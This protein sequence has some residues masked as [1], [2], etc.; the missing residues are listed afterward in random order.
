MTL[1]QPD[2]F[3]RRGG[4]DAMNS[5][6]QQYVTD[7][8]DSMAA[9]PTD[10]AGS[11]DLLRAAARRA[12][13]QTRK[14]LVSRQDADGSWCAELEGDTILES[15]TILLLAFLGREDDGLARRLAAYLLEKQLPEGGWALYP[16]GPPEISGSVKAYFALK[17]TGHDPGAE[18][19][20]RARDA[21]LARGGADAVN[22]HT[23]FYLGPA[24]PDLLRTMS[25]RAAGVRAAAQMVARQPAGRQRLV[26]D[27]H[28]AAVDH[29]GVSPCPPHRAAAGHPRAVPAASRQTG[30]RC[31]V[32]GCPAATGLLSWDRF[33]RTVDRLLKWCQRRRCA[34]AAAQGP[35]GRRTLDARP[36]RPQRRAGRDLSA[37]WSGASIA[38]K[39]LGYADDSPEVEYC[40]RSCDDLVID[41]PQPATARAAALQVAGLGHGHRGPGA[42]GRRRRGRRSGAPRGGRVAAASKQIRAARRLGRDGRCRAGR[43][44]LRVRQRF[45][46]R[47]RRHGDGADGAGSTQFRRRTGGPAAELAAPERHGLPRQRRQPD[48]PA[49][50][51]RACD[52]GRHGGGDRTRP[53]LAA[54]HAER[55]RRLGR[56]RSQQQPRVP[57]LRPL[58]RSQRDDR[59]QHARPDGPRAGSAGPSGPAPGRSGRR[60]G[61]GLRPRRART[62]TEAGSA[63]GASTTSTAPG[64]RSPG[65]RPSACRPTIRPWRPGPTGCWRT[66]SPAAAG[67]NRPTAMTFPQLRGQGPPTASQTAWA[68]M[69]LMAAGLERPSGRRPRHPLPD[70]HPEKT[71]PGTRRSSPAPAFPASFTCATTTIPS[72]S[73]AGAVAVGGEEVGFVAKSMAVE[74]LLATDGADPFSCVFPSRSPA[75]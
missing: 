18:P 36:L 19:M 30:R 67:A 55:R 20:Q 69:G 33:F 52:H 44:V 21:I 39:C 15:E 43:L 29:F 56:L 35:A 28:R 71:A 4:L 8:R 5:A 25:G 27:D 75:R 53:A 17:L 58:R 63:A 59:P 61:G 26:A 62:P 64:R 65:W 3:R 68:V 31:D 45:L 13:H 23:R 50:P 38:L 11:F 46:S 24:G 47:L 1:A 51:R 57:L 22:S 12:I 40:H 66:S 37:A 60:S 42:G 6:S 48:P 10:V 72:I 16:G 54:G 34:A 7:D 49:E 70:R 9:A 41:D 14:W 2:H 32:R 73:P 74:N